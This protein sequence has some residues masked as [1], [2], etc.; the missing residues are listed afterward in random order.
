MMVRH[1]DIF[2]ENNFFGSLLLWD[3]QKKILKKKFKF[4]GHDVSLKFYR[5]SDCPILRTFI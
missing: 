4:F 3:D 5:I 1:I 2:I